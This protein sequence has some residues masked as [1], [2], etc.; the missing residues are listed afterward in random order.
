MCP[1]IHCDTILLAFAEQTK[2]EVLVQSMFS[3]WKEEAIGDGR[4]SKQLKADCF[5]KFVL[6][7]AHFRMWRNAVRWGKIILQKYNFSMLKASLLL[8]LLPIIYS[9]QQ[10]KKHF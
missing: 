9:A 2:N 5:N 6:T 1:E 10:S 8:K 3:A 4:A 7:H